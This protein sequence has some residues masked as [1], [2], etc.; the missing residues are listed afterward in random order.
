MTVG[1]RSALALLVSVSSVALLTA[2][3]QAQDTLVLEP[4]T[5]L[6]TKTPEKAIDALAPV[7][8]IGK[9]KIDVLQPK[10]VSDL[11]YLVPGVWTQDRGDDPATTIN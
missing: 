4:I 2:S 6:A 1:R 10:R 8:V 11:F 5:V 7:T 3:A 9:D